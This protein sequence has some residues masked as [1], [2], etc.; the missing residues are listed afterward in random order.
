MRKSAPQPRLRK[1]GTGGRKRPRK[2]RQTS[3]VDDGGLFAILR[4]VL[5]CLVSVR[6]ICI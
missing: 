4:G 2:Y 6:F 5:V 1:T 3:E